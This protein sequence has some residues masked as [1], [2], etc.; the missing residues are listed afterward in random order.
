MK[1]ATEGGRKPP[2]LAGLGLASFSERFYFL[3]TTMM[4]I[5][6]LADQLI[7]LC[8]EG[9][10]SEA[11]KTL[12]ADTIISNEAHPDWSTTWLEAKIKKW[13]D[14]AATVNYTN[15]VISDPVFADDHFSISMISDGT[16]A[17]TGELFHMEEICV[18]KVEG[19]MIVEEWFFYSM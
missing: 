14:H 6:Q 7:A 5:K 19:G 16:N 13:E 8:R 3:F 18:Y 10:F 9:N 17:A 1:K 15:M 11:N 12:Y 4:D 2:A